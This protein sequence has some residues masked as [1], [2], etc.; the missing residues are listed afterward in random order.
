MCAGVSVPLADLPLALVE[1]HALRERVFDRGG[2]PE[3]RFLWRANP[4]LVPVWLDGRLVLARWGSRDRRGP[5]PYGPMTREESVE[6]GRWVAAR[7]V[8]A[9][10]PATYLLAGGVW[11]RLR[12]G[13]RALACPDPATG[14]PVA[15]LVCRAS[16]RYYQIMTRE[17][18]QPVLIGEVI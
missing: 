3:V 6:A 15:Y 4:A 18:Y 10:V 9:D 14:E 2:G 12:H 8:A 5:L 7:A 13:C 1:R 16:T 17:K 11:T